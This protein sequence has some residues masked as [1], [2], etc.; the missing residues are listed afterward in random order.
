[1]KRRKFIYISTLGAFA[2][3]APFLGCN[4]ANPALDKKLDVPDMLSHL[5][6]AKRITEIGKAY[7]DKFKNEYSIHQLENLLSED[8]N[9]KKF[10]ENTSDKEINEALAKKVQS[11][12]DEGRIV[13]VKGWVLSLTEARQCAL[14]SLVQA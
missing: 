5:T 2:I 11:D 8:A 3:S 7:G 10:T 4:N 6:D 13:R 9:G 12:F 14:F 1:M